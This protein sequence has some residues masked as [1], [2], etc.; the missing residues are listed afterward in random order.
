M[1]SLKRIGGSNVNLRKFGAAVRIE[2]GPGKGGQN[3]GYH[4]GF[5]RPT[6]M[7]SYDEPQ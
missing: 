4:V 5:M 6:V 1:L 2:G 3:C 7:P